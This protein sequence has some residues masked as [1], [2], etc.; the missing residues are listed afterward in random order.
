MTKVL[1]SSMRILRYIGLRNKPI[2]IR[3][4]IKIVIST[5]VVRTV[6]L[7][8]IIS[9]IIPVG[10]FTYQNHSGFHDFSSQLFI[11]AALCSA[12]LTYIDYIRSSKILENT[13]NS[14]QQIVEASEL[15]FEKNIFINHFNLLRILKCVKRN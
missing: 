5:N 9:T 11:L 14:L 3:Y 6:F 13:V 4:K 2:I 8:T 15:W 1:K 12:Y 7:A 10:I